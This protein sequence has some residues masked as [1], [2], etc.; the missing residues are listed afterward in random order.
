MALQLDSCRDASDSLDLRYAKPDTECDRYLVFLNGRTEWIEKYDYLPQDLGLDSSVGFVT[1]DHRGQGGSGGARSYVHSYDD[2]AD[3]CARVIEAA[4]GNK[5]YSVLAH[6][7]GSLIALYA[8]MRSKIKPERLVLCSPLFGLPDK[9]VPGPL[10]KPIAGI[11]RMVKLGTI[12]TGAGNHTRRSFAK[13]HLTHDYAR[14]RRMQATPYPIGSATFG[15]VRATFEAT[16]YIFA[17]ENLGRFR[18]PTLVMAGGAEEVVKPDAIAKW[19]QSASDAGCEVS[20]RWIPEA[21]H[22]LLSEL[23]Q[24]YGPARQE[25]RKFLHLE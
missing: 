23:E 6:S 1:M 9:P 11:M 25:I 10:A 12:G 13:N 15:W 14:Y 7:M 2:Y 5:P 21:R 3:D 16:D 19:I 18:T 4:V 24:Y 17:R 20:L 8:T 22:E